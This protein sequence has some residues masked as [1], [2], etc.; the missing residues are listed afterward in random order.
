MQTELDFLVVR[1]NDIICD[2]NDLTRKPFR[3]KGQVRRLIGLVVHFL[4][5][6]YFFSRKLTH[7]FSTEAQALSELVIQI[8]TT[9]EGCVPSTL[10]SNSADHESASL[11]AALDPGT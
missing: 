1:A 9:V 6:V 10:E 2:N 11:G 7:K 5:R 8:E 4:N 3:Y